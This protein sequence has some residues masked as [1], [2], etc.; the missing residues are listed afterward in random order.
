MEKGNFR[1]II[2]MCT[3]GCMGVS[4]SPRPVSSQVQVGGLFYGLKAYCSHKNKKF[5][6]RKSIW[7]ILIRSVASSSL[8]PFHWR[9]RKNLPSTS[10]N[11]TNQSRHWELALNSL[12][13]DG[14]WNYKWNLA[15]PG[16]TLSLSSRHT[17]YR[18]AWPPRGSASKGKSINCEVLRNFPR[19]CT[20]WMFEEE[21][22][23]ETLREAQ[24]AGEQC[25]VW[26]AGLLR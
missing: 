24:L 26:S 4:L 1:K 14:L 16:V 21:H 8:C 15:L 19:E 18:M 5:S 11:P 25:F 7:K 13:P 10:R 3:H 23:L 2:K 6:Q 9:A 17:A 22:D 20:C 12:S